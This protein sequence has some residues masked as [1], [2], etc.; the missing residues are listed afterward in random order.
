MCSKTQCGEKMTEKEVSKVIE[1]FLL[2]GEKCYSI[3]PPGERI[4]WFYD[5]TKHCFCERTQSLSDDYTQTYTE[6]EMRN[7]LRDMEFQDWKD[8]YAHGLR[9]KM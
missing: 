1:G 7:Y 3:Y 4:S 9:K 8:V 5:K 6:M 2:G